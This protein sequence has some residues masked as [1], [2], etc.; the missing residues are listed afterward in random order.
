MLS[1]IEHSVTSTTR[2][3][4]RVVD[5]VRHRRGRAGEVRFRHAPRAGIPGCASTIDAGMVC[6]AAPDFGGGEA[7]VH[8]AMALPGDDLHLGL[9]GDVLREI[10]VG[11]HD[12][13]A[14]RRATSTTLRALA[15]VQQMSD[16]RLHRGGGVDVGD[17][18]HAGIALPHQP[19]VGGGD[20]FRQ[21][22]AGARDRGSAPS[23]PGLSIFAV[24]AMK[25]TPASTI[26][27]ARR[28]SPRA[29]ARGCR[30]RCR[31]PRGRSPASVVVGQDHRVAL[32]LQREDCLDV[33]GEH[34]PLH[35][36]NEA[37]D[38][39]VEIRRY[40]RPVRTCPSCRLMLMSSISGAK[41]GGP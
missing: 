15:E 33:L 34:R 12:R 7:L 9:G 41:R 1:L 2:G 28:A 26:T 8:L 4:L 23:S 31:R 20:R 37:T 30:R 36:R 18:R 21:R 32:A 27:S 19:H 25:C 10:L 17:H 11:Q 22:A 24:S 40:A 35:R 14:R 39:V 29:P 5:V 13:R 38:P 3:G 6:R 16:L